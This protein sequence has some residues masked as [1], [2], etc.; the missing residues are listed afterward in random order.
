MDVNFLNNSHV[1]N[2]RNINKRL[3]I[4]IIIFIFLLSCMVAVNVW[5]LYKFY[6]A[7]HALVVAK[8]DVENLDSII[9]ENNQIK[10]EIKQLQNQIIESGDIIKAN[11]RILDLVISIANIIPDDAYLNAFSFK[12]TIKLGLDLPDI[13]EK[14]NEYGLGKIKLKGYTSSK[15]I[16]EFLERLSR[17][18]IVDNVKLVYLKY[19]EAPE[20]NLLEFSIK[21]L[22]NR[23]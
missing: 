4:F 5:Q 6:V 12:P 16:T 23:E 11:N 21:L 22:L 2:Q 19:P 8:K 13:A 7:K 9:Q 14:D 18:E 20:S 15:S 10:S 17:L 3:R 1:R